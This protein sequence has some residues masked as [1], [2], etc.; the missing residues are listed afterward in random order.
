M[1]TNDKSVE[2]D[3]PGSP[4]EP[5]FLDEGLIAA[6]GTAAVEDITALVENFAGFP[7]RAHPHVLVWAH[8]ASRGEPERRWAVLD[9][10]ATAAQAFIAAIGD[11]SLEDL[12]EQALETVSASLHESPDYVQGIVDAFTLMSIPSNSAT[13]LPEEWVFYASPECSRE[14]YTAVI[15]TLLEATVE[16]AAE[17][18]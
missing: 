2:R 11:I 12:Q 17:L 5:Y 9:A 16:F 3:F 7:E 6:D 13:E 15:V 1:N 18:D 8:Q 10:A 4:E 14:R